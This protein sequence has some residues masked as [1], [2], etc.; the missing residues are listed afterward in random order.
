MLL[1]RWVVTLHLSTVWTHGRH[2]ASVFTLS[3]TAA[4]TV[5]DNGEQTD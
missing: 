1:L 2:L 3:G 4:A 5:L